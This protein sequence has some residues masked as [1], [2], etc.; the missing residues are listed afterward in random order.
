MR[1]LRLWAI[2]ALAALFAI[3][4]VLSAWLFVHVGFDAEEALDAISSYGTNARLIVLLVVI[5]V[6][7]GLIEAAIVLFWSR[8]RSRRR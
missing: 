4:V 1:F 5:S 7:I 8:R 6:V 3:L 2:S